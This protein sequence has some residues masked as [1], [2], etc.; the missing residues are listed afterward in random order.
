MDGWRIDLLDEQGGEEQQMVDGRRRRR[1][2]RRDVGIYVC[3]LEVE[4]QRPVG[5][6]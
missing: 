2:R 5:S 3:L 4:V 6:E 1:R